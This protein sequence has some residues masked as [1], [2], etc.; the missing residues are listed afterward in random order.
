[1]ANEFKIKHG[2]ISTGNG[3]ITGEL[4]ITG[5]AYAD[6]NSRIA[7]RPWVTQFL[8]DN[9]YAT[10]GDITTAINNL[11]DSAPGALDTLNELAAAI[12][13]DADFAG[14]I[15]TSLA[16]KVSK[17]GDTM[18]GPLD[19]LYND[20][21][22][23]PGY[24][25]R[26]FIGTSDDL[27][28]AAAF[29]TYV[30]AGSY[31]FFSHAYSDGVFIG[32]V[33]VSAG[34]SN[35][36][37]TIAWGD[38]STEYFQFLYKGSQVAR[39][40]TVGRL[41]VYG[42]NSEE[43]NS[44]YAVTQSLGSASLESA[45]S[46]LRSDA[47]DSASGNLS[48]TGRLN[49]GA[50]AGGDANI[51]DYG[52]VAQFTLPDAGVRIAIMHAP[53]SSNARVTITGSENGYFQPIDLFITRNNTNVTTIIR[54]GVKVHDHS[55]DMLFSTDD[56]GN[57][58]VEKTL[59]TGR[60][61]VIRKVENYSTAGIR[62]LDGGED[63]GTGV[64]ESIIGLG[65]T[66]VGTNTVW[67]SGNDGTGSGLDADKLDGLN[68]TQFVR[69]D[70]NDTMSGRLDNS[71]GIVSRSIDIATT[72]NR[73]I[74][75]LASDNVTGSYGDLHLQ[76]YGGDLH[77]LHGGGNFYLAG[78]L[79]LTDDSATTTNQAR[80]IDFTGFDK[81]GT[82]DYTDRAYIQHTTATGGHSGSVLVISSQND[83]GDGIAFLTHASSKLK[84]N[85]NNIATET[86]TTNNF[87]LTSALGSL[88]LEDSIAWDDVTG[89][90][91]TFTPDAHTH[92]AGD[93]TSGTFA[94]AR[95]SG[96][97]TIDVAGT[98]TRSNYLYTE[99]NRTISPR[100]IP[101]GHLKFGFTSFSNNNSGP[102][103]DFLHLRSYTDSSGGRD[104]L[105]MFS[106]SD[107]EIRLWQQ[108]FDSTDN[109]ADF[110][111]VAF[112]DELQTPAIKSNGSTPSL[113]SG[114][115]AAEVRTLIGAGTSSSD[116]NYYLSGASF[117][118]SNGVL[119]LTVSGADDQT[120]DLDGRY[121][122]SNHNHDGRYMLLGG[123]AGV[124]ADIID[125]I[126]ENATVSFD[127]HVGAPYGNVSIVNN[128]VS[129][130]AGRR[131]QFWHGD[132][133]DGGVW[134]RG[135]QGDSIGW[136][137]WQKLWTSHDFDPSSFL[138]TTG[139]AADSNLLDGINSTSFLRSD[140]A[141][142]ASGK[143][144]FNAGIT[145]FDSASSI[146]G[147]NFDITGVNAITIND[148]GEG[149]IWSN[150]ANGNIILAT[151]DDAADNILNLTGTGASF[152][153]NSATVATQSWVTDQNY[154]T[155][156]NTNWNNTYGFITASDSITGN[157][158]TATTASKVSTSVGAGSNVDLLYAQIASNDYFRL[159]VGGASN[160]GSVEIATAD[161][162]TEPIYVRQYTGGF[163]TLQRTATLL[164]G[165]G[166]TSFPGTVTAPTFT[167]G[168]SGN[169]TTATTLATARNIALA[170]DVTG[171]ANFNGGSNI[172]I[173]AT[174]VNDSHTHDTRYYTK[175][176]S[177]SRFVNAS[178]D[179]VTGD[180]SVSG[181]SLNVT[182]TAEG[183][184]AFFVDGVNGR[185]FTITDSLSDSLFSVNTVSGLPVIEAFSD[186]T[187]KL[188]PFSNPVTIDSTGILAIGGETA[189]TQSYVTTAIN[190]LVGGAPG[191]LNTLNELAAAINDDAS[192]A[193]SVTSSLSLKAPLASPALTGNPTAPTQATSNNSTRIATTAFVKAQGY[194][195]S[196]TNHYLSNAAFN[197]SDGVLTLTVTGN[198]NQT[199][200][201]DGR[202]LPL[203]GGNMSGNIG[204]TSTGKGLEWTMN[205]D[206][207]YIK[208]F[209]T[210]DGDTNSRL[211]YATS[212]NGNEYH[213]F[214]IAGTE[215][216]RV[217]ASGISATGYN[218]SNWDTAHGWGN[219]A[220][221]GYLKNIN[222]QTLGDSQFIRFSH[223]NEFNGND[224]K[225]GS[226]LF[227]TGLNLVGTRT[228]SALPREIRTWGNIL[229]SVDRTDD[230]GGEVNRWRIIF[231]EILD[232]AGQ[233][234]KNL[235]NPEGEK[236][237]GEYATGTVL[238]WKGGKNIP[239]AE[240]ADHMRMG[241]AVKDVASP[242]IQ[243]AEPVLVT[244]KVNEG[245][246]LVTSRKEGHAE[247]ISP[248]L[249]RQQGLYDCVLGKA[250]ENGEGDS[251]L[252]KTWINI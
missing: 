5:A 57:I 132:T 129:H 183:S 56:D 24:D 196:D 230:L 176:T 88:A 147:N 217:T 66:A 152:A 6:N 86:W 7:T 188:G 107:M 115:S 228:D 237:V 216:M 105:L 18:T 221:A 1:M 21:A 225:I 111:D 209:N 82:T 182:S 95:L 84:H 243:G 200:D 33:P 53:V 40:D 173:T 167:G 69:S 159:R 14:T 32:S 143:I 8:S 235:Q 122:L 25:N 202:Y 161:D 78:N 207:A 51:I 100:E 125:R 26:L 42:G 16:G 71:T 109:Y 201:L 108:D 224:G 205:T 170:G 104:N 60:T 240:Y 135:R 137:P 169:A 119:T 215:R 222:G 181:A 248:E 10:S 110:R 49:F 74:Q 251:Y 250:L 70:A 2:F 186:N 192:F 142:T 162:G 50:N 226:A 150:G 54:E 199:V 214:L 22:S 116:T 75:G 72:G 231:C 89:K 93:I 198:T 29:P 141:D 177:D 43:W 233:H 97:Y 12:G 195:T 213:R 65:R 96:T 148:P 206:G 165:S 23:G 164:D 11:V 20:H 174:V 187:V 68:S 128:F 131:A 73:T 106:K 98:S 238:V 157:A 220:S 38:D 194:V 61:I 144:T 203:G 219:H 127:N 236:S 239:C 210:G 156:G 44:A 37:A 112:K 3:S 211:E 103:A 180:L 252:V 79:L 41:Y 91:T 175:S 138:T 123:D 55:N 204:W 241:I 227:G 58:F 208:F 85:S 19:I 133:P 46:F 189:A 81:E 145:G 35:Y 155:D 30:P 158:A 39:L 242:L 185:L 113:N 77:A 101:N 9:S 136:H 134:W 36:Y 92:A 67:H 223:P 218:K 118:T 15:T 126:E 117:S 102:W 140:A 172:S 114:I 212:D 191:A 149:I 146:S 62:I 45:N 90:P 232:S 163:A 52:N 27:G 171:S 166:N 234:E 80:T 249:M 139:K 94:A 153:I 13:D 160:A 179:N 197:T 63:A 120:V 121:S 244:G 245:D 34:A 83:S 28:L 59:T 47:D 130:Y 124:Y 76:H 246:Y 178:G 247:A 229:P 99:D 168:L 190:N 193:S 17:S 64:D 48:F 151:V 31:G 154:I 4:R 87:T 184:E